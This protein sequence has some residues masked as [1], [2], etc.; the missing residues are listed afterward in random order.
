MLSNKKEELTPEVYYPAVRRLLLQT[1]DMLWV[2]HLET[3]DYLRSS[4]NLRAYG[5]R[6]PL[7][8]YK[9]EGLLLF[10]NLEHSYT[11]NVIRLL[12]QLSAQMFIKREEA[13]VEEGRDDSVLLGDGVRKQAEGAVAASGGSA[14]ASS[15]R[16]PIKKL[17]DIGRNDP[18]PCGSGNKYKKCGLVNSEEHQKR[19]QTGSAIQ[20]QSKIGG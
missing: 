6:D 5:Q 10:Q 15:A 12:P 4:V 18:C 2:E 19:T 8:E 3:M 20:K 13:Q 9:K 16:A 11:E 1:I 14:S 7:I 17:T